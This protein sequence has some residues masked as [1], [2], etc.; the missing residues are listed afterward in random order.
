MIGVEGDPLTDIRV[1]EH[2]RSVIKEGA[3]VCALDMVKC[4]D[5]SP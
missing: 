4:H 3:Q 2:V 1:L 5:A